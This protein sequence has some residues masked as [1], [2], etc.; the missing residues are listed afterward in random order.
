MRKYTMKKLTRGLGAALIAAFSLT[1]SGCGEKPTV[2]G[3]YDAERV[4]SEAAQ[5]KSIRDEANE[6]MKEKQAEIEGKMK[7]KQT[8]LEAKFKAKQE[9]L[10]ERFKAKEDE[11][12]EKVREKPPTSQEEADSLQAEA[13]AEGKKLQDEA[14]SEMNK[15][16]D[17]AQN[18][19]LRARQEAFSQMQGL[20]AQYQMRMRQKVEN[21]VHEVAQAKKIDAVL[22]N[23]VLEK[24]VL[25][26]GVDITDDLIEKLK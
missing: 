24:T 6:K 17:D 16:R 20:R 3:Y 12:N 26:G 2:I 18:E 15:L 19:A 9:E 22:E 21:A 4:D 11:F 23:N 14:E 8:E 13:E 7:E 5:I 25:W 1:A 10:E